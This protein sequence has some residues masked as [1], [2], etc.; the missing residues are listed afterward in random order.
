M[1]L[2]TWT[3]R[4]VDEKHSENSEMLY[5]KR[6]GKISWTD[7]MKNEEV[8]QTVRDTQNKKKED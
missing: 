8:L 6:I 3:L 4:K 1:V 7:C 5:W 2:K